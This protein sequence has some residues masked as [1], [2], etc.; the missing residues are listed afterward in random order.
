MTMRIKLSATIAIVALGLGLATSFASAAPTKTGK[1]PIKKKS[2]SG[3]PGLGPE[4]N[5][6]QPFGGKVEGFFTGTLAGLSVHNNGKF[7]LDLRDESNYV[8]AHL[9]GC[10]IRPEAVQYLGQFVGKKRQ[11]RVNYRKDCIVSV[12]AVHTQ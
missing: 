5:L 9:N 12:A 6:H 2:K 11:I 7:T 3:R 1:I 10:G 8:I 4:H